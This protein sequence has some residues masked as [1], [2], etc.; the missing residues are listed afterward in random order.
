MFIKQFVK[1][2]NFYLTLAMEN[3]KMN[4]QSAISNQQSAISNQQSAISNQQSA[5]SPKNRP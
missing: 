3:R 5:I 1:I 2:K 4:Q